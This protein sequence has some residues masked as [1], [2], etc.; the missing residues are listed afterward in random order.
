M[1]VHELKTWPSAFRAMVEGKKSFEYR[2]NDRGFQ[3]GDRLKLYEYIPGKRNTGKYTGD[4]LIAKVIFI[5]ENAPP[6][7]GLP[8]GYC[9]MQLEFIGQ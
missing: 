7:F 6:A 9:I 5:L 8:D 1:T 3:V 4:V 2:K